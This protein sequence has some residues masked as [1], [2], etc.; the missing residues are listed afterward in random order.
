MLPLQ[1]DFSLKGKDCVV[2]EWCCNVVSVCDNPAM[3]VRSVLGRCVL[4]MDH[5][6]IWIVNCVG[7]Y[8]YKVGGGDSTQPPTAFAAGNQHM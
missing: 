6:C 8:N 4:K 7:L 5:Y 1:Y 2:Q 3:A